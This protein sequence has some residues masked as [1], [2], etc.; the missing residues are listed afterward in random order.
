MQGIE[1]WD[2]DASSSYIL[3]CYGFEK[4]AR[5]CIGNDFSLNHIRAGMP[6]ALTISRTSVLGPFTV[7]LEMR[8]SNGNASYDFEGVTIVSQD[9][10]DKRVGIAVV[11]LP[12]NITPGGYTIALKGLQ[13][14]LFIWVDPP[15]ADYTLVAPTLRQLQEEQERREREE[16]QR[17]DIEAELRRKYLEDNA[18]ASKAGVVQPAPTGNTAVSVPGIL[19]FVAVLAIC[20]GA[21]AWA[22]P[23]KFKQQFERLFKPAE[24]RAAVND[25]QYERFDIDMSDEEEII[26]MNAH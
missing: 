24:G 7:S 18:P 16:Q 23:H 1:S 11:P 2:I 26:E 9:H 19:S 5:L 13:L 6:L 25:S 8:Q 21:A 4:P 10:D 15:T 12:S 17:K 3:R 22:Y 14:P 20:I